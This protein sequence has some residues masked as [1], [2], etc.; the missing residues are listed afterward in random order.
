MKDF[1][2]ESLEILEFLNTTTKRRFR[3]TKSNLFGIKARLKED[4]SLQEIQE[5]I[6]IKTMEWTNN[7]QMSV[8]LNPVT[9]FRPSN[10]EKYINQVIAVKDNPKL[11]EKHFKSINK[12][13]DKSISDDDLTD[14]YG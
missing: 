3:P 8:H 1:E 6:I 2:K 4:Y 13:R 14:L 7:P 12:V 9:L 11:Y 5:V 10:F